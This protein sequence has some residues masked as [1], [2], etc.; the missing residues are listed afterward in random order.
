[1]AVPELT[2]TGDLPVCVH[3]A[4]L[5]ET[6]RRFGIGSDRRKLLALRLQRVLGAPGG[7]DRR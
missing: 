7:N 3:Q 2:E 1:M 5:S 6:V 4:T